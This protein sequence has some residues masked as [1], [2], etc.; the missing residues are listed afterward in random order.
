MKK[1]KIKQISYE[2]ED[3]KEIKSLII[4]TLVIVVLGIGLYFLTDKVTTKNNLTNV[5]FNYEECL[6]EN[7]F[8]R[9]YEEYFVFA[10]ASDDENASVYQTLKLNNEKKEEAIKLYY[11][12]MATNFNKSF[13]SSYSNKNPITVND[14][15]INKSALIHIK[16]GKVIAYYETLEDYKNV[17]N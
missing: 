7:M 11:V 3:T 8:T 10:Y 1:K 4:I 5:E 6:I 9:P 2:S 17:L 16:N 14:V 13:L 15:K 12:D